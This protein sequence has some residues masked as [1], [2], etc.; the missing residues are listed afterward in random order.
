[1]EKYL[2]K[3]IGLFIC[4]Y[5][6]ISN[7]FLN[8]KL[9][10]S[11]IIYY[12]IWPKN[13]NELL[14]YFFRSFFLQDVVLL[15][16]LASKGLYTEL[17]FFKNLKLLPKGSSV[18]YTLTPFSPKKRKYPK[19]SQGE[20]LFEY[21]NSFSDLQFYP[22]VSEIR[23][24]ENKSYMHQKFDEYSI[25]SPKTIVIYDIPEDEILDQIQFPILTKLPNSNQ[26]KGIDIHYE[27][28]SLLKTID[29]KLKIADAVIIQEIREITFDIRVVVINNKVV[30]HYW[31]HKNN[32]EEGFTTTST[33]NGGILDTKELPHSIKESC[34]ITANKLNL[35]CAAFD[36]TFD[37]FMDYD[38]ICF[39]EVSP[40][41]MLNP[42]PKQDEIQGPYS[43]YKKSYLR[44]YKE[45]IHQFTELKK[46]QINSWKV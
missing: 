19:M 13:F 10:N 17:V 5:Y 39:F 29:N 45:L 35:G 34:I 43:Q 42:L 36:V 25:P 21:L 22:P 40:S 15:K 8:R 30:Y 7:R 46:L 23:F 28:P 2:G 9:K 24:W 3:I 4:L 37:S 26:S 14:I 20:S 18:V 11:K 44:F 12:A 32:L 31:R 41:F 38:D 1:M 27:I 16:A 6:F 33:S